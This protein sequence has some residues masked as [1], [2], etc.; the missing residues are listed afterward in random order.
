[1]TSGFERFQT[2]GGSPNIRPLA[3]SIVPIAPSAMTVR[4][5]AISSRHRS[6]AAPPSARRRSSSPGKAAGS[7]GSG[8]AVGLWR[9][10]RGLM[11]A[12]L[13]LV[14]DPTSVP[15]G[16]YNPLP[17][18]QEPRLID[19]LGALLII[20]VGVVAGTVNTIVGAG[21][22]LTFPTLLFLGYP[23]LVA[24]VSNTV[25]L[26]VGQHQRGGRLPERAR[27]PADQ[28]ATAGGGRGARWTDRGVPP[29]RAAGQRI[30][31]DRAGPHP[32]RLRARR[33]PAEAIGLGPRTP[34]ASR[35][36]PRRW[37]LAPG[38][39]GLP[40]RH[41]RRL[42]RGRPGRHPH[43]AARDPRRRRSATPQRAQE[44][45]RGR[46]QWRGRD[47]VHLRRARSRGCRRSSSR[48]DRRSAASSAPWSDGRLSP[49]ALR[50]AIITVGTLVAARLLLG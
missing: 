14:G 48:S 3:N 8:S 10:R 37:W 12:Y 43:R 22:L 25:G 2:S 28:G 29:A 5:A 40:D 44:P 1:M 47:P 18:S 35:R 38:P 19:P 15:P 46:H 49:F 13:S 41:L 21:S 11:Q 31:P 30:R 33:D 7:N 26:G 6:L 36:G 27:R 4:F 32:D 39:R 45:H 34:D 23:P 50:A 24:N 17:T 20:A 42:F 9:T 16:P